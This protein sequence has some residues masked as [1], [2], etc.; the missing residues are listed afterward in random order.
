MET[1]NNKTVNNVYRLKPIYIIYDE[2]K[3][4]LIF[5]SPYNVDPYIRK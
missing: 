5:K 4:N 3:D 2:E 1:N